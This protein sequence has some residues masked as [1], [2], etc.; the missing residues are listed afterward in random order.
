MS[1]TTSIVGTEQV[2]NRKDTQ[3]STDQVIS[4]KSTTGVYGFLRKEVGMTNPQTLP[5]PKLF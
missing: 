5:L 3:S 4:T 1:S 2:M